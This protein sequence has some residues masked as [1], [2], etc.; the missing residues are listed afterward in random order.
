M[1]MC[2]IM[3]V[4]TVLSGAR[5]G[6]CHS[7][8]SKTKP[9]KEKINKQTGKLTTIMGINTQYKHICLDSQVGNYQL[10]YK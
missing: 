10:E 8:H 2:T 6:S 3:L 5:K 9:S 7:I 4:M 1:Q